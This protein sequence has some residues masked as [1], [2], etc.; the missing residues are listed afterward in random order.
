M[1]IERFEDCDAW[2][3]AR[4]LRKMVS[5]LTRKS[6]VH[7]DS[8]FCNQIRGA[9]LSVMSNIAEGFESA[10]NKEFIAFLGYARRSCGEVRSQLYAAL[11]DGYLG[12]K[13]FGEIYEQATKTGK[14]I[15]GL[16]SY[17]RKKV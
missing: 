14:L 15:T 8:V 9:A 5:A 7:R 11:D 1:K 17:L 13:E 2:K 3:E 4:T 6:P 10:T 16:L 12:R